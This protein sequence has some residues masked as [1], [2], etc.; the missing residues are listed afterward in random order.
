MFLEILLGIYY[1]LMPTL[2]VG[3]AFAIS[4]NCESISLKWGMII[5]CAILAL[6]C[7][8]IDIKRIKCLIERHRNKKE[9]KN[10]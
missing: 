4:Y 1:A 3:S 9:D 5:V 7:I 8:V 10:D 2:F 6:I